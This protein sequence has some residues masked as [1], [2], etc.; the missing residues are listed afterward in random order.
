MIW[1]AEKLIARPAWPAPAGYALRTYTASDEGG[2]VA[3]M[4]AAGFADWDVEKTRAALPQCISG[5]FFVITHEA[6]GA[7]VA[8]AVA[9]RN[10]MEGHPSGGELGWVAGDPEHVGKGLGRAVCAAAT[11]RFLETGYSDIFLRTDDHRLAAIKTYLKLGYV[12]LLFA[13]DMRE[14]W[15]EVLRQLGLS[16][17]L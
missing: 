11:R 8:T 12:P 7:L 9:I 14:R 13:P 10:P 15:Q 6:T 17:K 2:H 4:R 3:L 5:G 1:P 16:E